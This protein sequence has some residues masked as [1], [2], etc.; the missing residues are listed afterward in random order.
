MGPLLESPRST[1]QAMC[2]ALVPCPCPYSTSVHTPKVVPQT[3]LTPSH[4]GC[5]QESD[6]E[7]ACG[8]EGVEGEGCLVTPAWSL[9]PAVPRWY[10]PSSWAGE[11]QA[12]PCTWDHCPHSVLREC[13][14]LVYTR[15]CSLLSGWFGSGGPESQSGLPVKGN[16]LQPTGPDTWSC[17]RVLHC[18]ICLHTSSC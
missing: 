11:S 12:R 18:R 8:T 15:I 3:V 17:C 6:S 16:C 9:L 10:T 13:S 7:W 4:R 14:L 1:H 2:S 5:D